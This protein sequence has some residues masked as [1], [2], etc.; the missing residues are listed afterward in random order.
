MTSWHPRSVASKHSLNASIAIN[1]KSLADVRTRLHHS[2]D[3]GAVSYT[4]RPAEHHRLTQDGDM[5]IL[6]I[7]LITA[8]QLYHDGVLPVDRSRSVEITLDGKNLGAFRLEWLRKPADSIHD[9]FGESILLRFDKAEQ[10]RQLPAELDVEAATITPLKLEPVGMWDPT[11]EYWGEESEPM[12]EWAKAIIIKGPRPLF[13]MEQILPG[14]DPEDFDSDPII[15]ANELR[16][17]GRTKQAREL[18][19][20]LIDQDVRCLDAHAHLSS[21]EFDRKPARPSST[22]SAAWRSA[23]CR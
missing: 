9:R 4:M 23:G 11:E 21:M 3:T 6:Q 15:Q 5:I 14:E 1:G 10:A 18:L 22:T 7:P 17:H 13:E 19:S 8:V 2:Y 16:A 12:E 20:D